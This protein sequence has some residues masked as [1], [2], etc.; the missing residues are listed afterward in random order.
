MFEVTILIPVVDNDGDTFPASVHDA[1]ESAILDFF[2]G[3]TR[4]PIE[5]VGA[6]LNA[7]GVT[8]RDATRVYIVA[9]ASLGNGDKI[10]ALVRFAKGLY[11]QEAIFI[12]YLGVV[13][14][15]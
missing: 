13:E 12:R 11:S 1:F 6:W 5:A 4:L 15:I 3:F 9:V 2:G 7:A 8:Y 10:V 14:I